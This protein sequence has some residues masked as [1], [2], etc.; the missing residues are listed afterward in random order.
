VSMAAAS[1]IEEDVLSALVNLGYQRAAGGEGIAGGNAWWEEYAEFRRAV[2][3]NR[4][5]VLSKVV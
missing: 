1:P 4:W 5:Q 3:G 2:F